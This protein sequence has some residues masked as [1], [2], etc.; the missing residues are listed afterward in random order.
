MQ[1]VK[2]VE[3][4]RRALIHNMA[5]TEHITTKMTTTTSKLFSTVPMIKFLVPLSGLV[6]KLIVVE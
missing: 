2:G 5:G 6:H 3:V 1:R 4:V